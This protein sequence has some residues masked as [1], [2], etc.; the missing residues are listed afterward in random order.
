MHVY[1]VA[2]PVYQAAL[3]L[4]EQEIDREAFGR[5]KD[6]VSEPE[7]VSAW[8]WLLPPVAFV[9][10]MRRRGAYRNAVWSLIPN[11]LMVEFVRYG[12]KSIA[13]MMVAAGAFLI[14]TRET[15]KLHHALEWGDVGFW[16]LLLLM[17]LLSFSFTVYRTRRTERTRS[18]GTA[19]QR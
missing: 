18:Q 5:V 4:A 15:W 12:D 3:E 9:V 14:A 17:A 13:W 7:P 10:Q 8:W 11:Q 6:A 2:G 16:G 19:G 1:V